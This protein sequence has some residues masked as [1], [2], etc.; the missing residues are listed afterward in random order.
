LNNFLM[1]IEDGDENIVKIRDKN[2][3]ETYEIYD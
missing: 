2:A 3:K 1:K